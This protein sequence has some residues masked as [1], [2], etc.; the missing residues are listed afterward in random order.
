MENTSLFFP[1]FYQAARP[2]KYRKTEEYY[3]DPDFLPEKGFL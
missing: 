2:G 1:L 3:R